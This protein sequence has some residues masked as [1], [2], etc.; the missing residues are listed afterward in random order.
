MYVLEINSYLLSSPSI[1]SYTLPHLP[2][3][4]YLI[5]GWRPCSEGQHRGER[6]DVRRADLF[7]S[8]RKGSAGF[9][10]LAWEAGL[11]EARW[12]AFSVRILG[13]DFS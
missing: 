8:R 2:L 1:H 5:L 13:K 4:Y 6:L 11:G 9:L 10:A 12:R 3:H 7:P